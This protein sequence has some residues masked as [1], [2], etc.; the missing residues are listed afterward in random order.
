MCPN[1]L[2]ISATSIQGRKPGMQPYLIILLQLSNWIFGIIL[3]SKFDKTF[4]RAREESRDTTI[5]RYKYFAAQLI[6]VVVLS[7]DVNEW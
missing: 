7:W 4:V 2:W 6:L 1:N 5:N 3:Y